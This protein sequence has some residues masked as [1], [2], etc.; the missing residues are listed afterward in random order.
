MQF[1]PVR[2]GHF[3]T[4]LFTASDWLPSRSDSFNGPIWSITPAICYT[5]PLQ[6]AIALGFSLVHRPIPYRTYLFWAAFVLPRLFASR[7]TCR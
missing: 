3:V 4:Q 1:G 2:F 6:L 7:L 5:L